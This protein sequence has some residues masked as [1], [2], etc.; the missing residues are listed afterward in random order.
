MHGAK[1][2]ASTPEAYRAYVEDVASSAVDKAR[3]ERHAAVPRHDRKTG[4]R[5]RIRID[6]HHTAATEMRP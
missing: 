3:R 2:R 4:G 5:S 6:G 1:A